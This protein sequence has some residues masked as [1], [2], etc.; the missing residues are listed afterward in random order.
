M[1]PIS[2][3]LRAKSNHTRLD[4]FF[5]ATQFTGLAKVP[6]AGLFEGVDSL[7][8]PYQSVLHSHCGMILSDVSAPNVS[9]TKSKRARRHAHLLF[10]YSAEMTL[11]VK[12]VLHGNRHQ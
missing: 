12:S 6:S 7:F 8:A 11:V 1:H 5:T 3:H 4:F 10:K 9:V 2:H